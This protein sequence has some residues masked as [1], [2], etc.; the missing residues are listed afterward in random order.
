MP[1]FSDGSSLFLQVTRTNIKAWMNLNF[2][3]ILSPTTELAALEHLKSMYNVGSILAPPFLNGSSS[4]LLVTSTSIKSC[5]GLKFSKI[6]L[7]SLELAAL[8]CLKNSHSHN[9]RSVGTLMPSFL[10]GPSSFLQVTR[11]TIKAWMR[12]IFCQ[13]PSSATE[14]AA[15]E[16]LKKRMYNVVSTLSAF[17]FNWI[18]IILA[19]NK[20]HSTILDGYGIWKDLSRVCVVSC[21]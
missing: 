15:F 2:C 13:I 4:Y 8:E 5:K 11:T 18:V 16:S 20:N 3:Q 9:G 19:G 1:Y 10:N 21:P 7:G 14:L 6:R 12:L 17:I